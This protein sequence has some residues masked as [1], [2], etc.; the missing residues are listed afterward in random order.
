MISGTRDGTKTRIIHSL[1]EQTWYNILLKPV[2]CV[3][4]DQ[5]MYIIKR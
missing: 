4:S 3:S 2:Y 5:A 1:N